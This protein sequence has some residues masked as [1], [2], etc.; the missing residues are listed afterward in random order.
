M[1]YFGP[2]RNGVNLKANEYFPH[3]LGPRQPDHGIAGRVL[4]CSSCS[5][6]PKRLYSHRPGPCGNFNA[7]QHC[8]H[9]SYNPSS[10]STSTQ[11]RSVKR[12]LLVILFLWVSDCG[13]CL[14]PAHSALS[15]QPEGSSSPLSLCSRQD[16][17]LRRVR[18]K[19]LLRMSAMLMARRN[20]PL[21]MNLVLISEIVCPLLTQQSNDVI[22]PKRIFSLF[23]LCTP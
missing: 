18:R 8:R 11:Q 16:L 6:H 23:S 9:P 20:N 21:G 7:G 4:S 5:A 10:K 3:D 12:S 17:V 22:L 2:Q 13:R 19:L 15:S 14:L 1:H